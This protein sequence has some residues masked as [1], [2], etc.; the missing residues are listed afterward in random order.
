M[1][2]DWG[3]TFWIWTPF[4]ASTCTAALACRPRRLC[5]RVV[6][7][8]GRSEF[9]GSIHPLA[10][11]FC[12]ATAS[13]PREVPALTRS[14]PGPVCVVMEPEGTDDKRDYTGERASRIPS[15]NSTGDRVVA[16]G[17]GAAVWTG[18]PPTVTATST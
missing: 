5:A 17:T 13:L 3:M 4:S 18:F 9:P 15:I 12:L 8:I 11:A 10:T 2:L 16:P 7:F 6:G 14:V 1:A